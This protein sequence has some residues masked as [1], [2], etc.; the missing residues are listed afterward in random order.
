MDK[1]DWFEHSVPTKLCI[2]G[3]RIFQ[4]FS[5]GE[6]FS[7]TTMDAIMRL[8]TDMDKKVQPAD[9][10]RYTHYMPATFS[11]LATSSADYTSWEATRQWFVGEHLG[12]DVEHCCMIVTPVQIKGRWSCYFWNFKDEEIVV[13]DPMAM[14]KVPSIVEAFHEETIHMLRTALSKCIHLYFRGWDVDLTHWE[15]QYRLKISKCARLKNSGFYTSHFARYYTVLHWPLVCQ[16]LS[17][18]RYRLV[19]QLLRMEGNEIKIP[20]LH[21]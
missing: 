13:L 1:V 9:S 16:R 6:N 19:C 2:I 7:I 11:V 12:Y 4:Q 14:D 8:Y 3:L 17:T 20:Y 18:M 21:E 15:V 5:L 10:N